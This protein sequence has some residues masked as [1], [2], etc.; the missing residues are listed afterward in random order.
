MGR[1]VSIDYGLKRIGLAI[2][3]PNNRFALPWMTLKAPCSLHKTAY[4]LLE[5]CHQ[6]GPID[7]FVLGWPIR[8][9]GAKGTLCDKIE[10]FKKILESIGKI[11]VY[12][13]DE[14]LTSR[15]AESLLRDSLSKKK[16][17]EGSIDST[18]ASLI[19]ETFLKKEY[20]KGST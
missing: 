15:L 7:A 6:K 14:R 17:K 4:T 18:A 12:L 1:V 16:P 13:I 20:E 10:S 11:P 5:L 8:M 19:L 3:D 9:N 2:S